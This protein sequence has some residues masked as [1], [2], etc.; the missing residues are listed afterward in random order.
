MF[1][2]RFSTINSV[3]AATR[4]EIT[5]G[6]P[7]YEHYHP[8]LSFSP[9]FSS[10]SLSLSL[11]PSLVVPFFYY[12]SLISLFLSFSSVSLPLSLS[13]ALFVSLSLTLFH[14]AIFLLPFLQVFLNH[15]FFTSPF[16]SLSFYHVF[17]HP[18]LSPPPPPL[19]SKYLSVMSW[20]LSLLLNLSHF[21][22]FLSILTLSPCLPSP[23]PLPPPSLPYLP[24]SAPP[25]SS[26]TFPPPLP[27]FTLI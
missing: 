14:F 11:P 16:S 23:T 12:P 7:H 1:N 15:Y 13:L 4:T 18:F 2:G 6:T 5:Q 9:S 25:P 21:L 3:M 20:C 22:S 10:V 26:S 8:F 27:L 24:S 17:Y 19:F